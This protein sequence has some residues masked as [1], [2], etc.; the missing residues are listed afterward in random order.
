MVTGSQV[1]PLRIPRSFTRGYYAASVRLISQRNERVWLCAWT[2]TERFER[3]SRPTY[4]ER[5]ERGRLRSLKGL[6]DQ[7]SS[8]I[9]ATSWGWFAARAK[10]NEKGS[11][12][13]SQVSLWCFRQM[14][15]LR[16]IAWGN[17]ES[18]ELRR[19]L[20]GLVIGNDTAI[21]ARSEVLIGCV[22][23]RLLKEVNASIDVDELSA[24]WML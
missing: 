15:L 14:T 7:R 10:V 24:G 20:I 22:V 23:D 16:R 11:P 1:L 17:G 21:V 12:G 5:G 18:D 4:Q 13:S 3:D 8:A 2:E 19:K 9:R 6:P